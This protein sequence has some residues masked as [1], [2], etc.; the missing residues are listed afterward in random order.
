MN[1]QHRIVRSD[2]ATTV[3]IGGDRRSPEPSHLIVKLPGGVVEIARA[4]DG[5]Y[6]IH[7]QRLMQICE[8]T[9]EQAGVIIGSRVDWSPEVAARRSIPELPEQSEIRGL[10]VRIAVAA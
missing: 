3:I 10:S 4:S 8:E 9:N 1:K 7:T 2:D 5:S 6:W